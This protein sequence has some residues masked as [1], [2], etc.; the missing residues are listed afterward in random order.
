MCAGEA[1][2]IPR[3]GSEEGAERLQPRKLYVQYGKLIASSR[4]ELFY[5]GSADR[6]RVEDALLSAFATLPRE[7]IQETFPSCPHSARQE[8]LRVT[9]ELDVTQGKLGMGFSCGSCRISPGGLS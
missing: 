9:D 5:S 2:G 6:R 8:V 7:N 3:L 1:Y 4:L